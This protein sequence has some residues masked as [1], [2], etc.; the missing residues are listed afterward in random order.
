MQPLLHAVHAQWHSFASSQHLKLFWCGFKIFSNDILSFIHS[1]RNF[2]P[3][4][5]TPITDRYLGFN[6]VQNAYIYGITGGTATLV[7]AWNILIT[8][9][10]TADV[11]DEIIFYRFSWR[12][13]RHWILYAIQRVLITHG[14]D[15]IFQRAPAACTCNICWIGY[16]TWIDYIATIDDI[17]SWLDHPCWSSW[18]CNFFMVSILCYGKCIHYPFKVTTNTSSI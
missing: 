4:L 1:F 6:S 14:G 3:L 18:L 16:R 10:L 13:S 11:R 8:S 7:M 9:M 2:E 12:E 15:A 5:L 17:S